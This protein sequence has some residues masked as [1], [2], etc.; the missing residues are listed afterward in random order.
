[1]IYFDDM[2]EKTRPSLRPLVPKNERLLNLDTDTLQVRLG[3]AVVNLDNA[4]ECQ[5]LWLL[6]SRG[7]E[8]VR[9]EEIVHLLYAD[10]SEGAPV[11]TAVEQRIS[12]LRKK[13]AEFEKKGRK[14]L[15]RNERRRGYSLIES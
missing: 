11:S 2:L 15:I 13:L 3:D 14:I 9:K 1:M 5:I 7:G 12:C 6:N 4:Q 8:P 10:R